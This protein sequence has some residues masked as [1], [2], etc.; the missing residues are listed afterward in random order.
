MREMNIFPLS[1][2]ILVLAENTNNTNE[3]QYILD[4]CSEI[5]IDFAFNNTVIFDV[6][7]KDMKE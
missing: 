1:R 5:N 4:Q 6:S 7:K 2:A 3:I